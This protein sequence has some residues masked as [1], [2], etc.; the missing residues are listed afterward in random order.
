MVN[1]F[2]HNVYFHIRRHVN[3]WTNIDFGL[4]ICL[5]YDSTRAVPILSIKPYIK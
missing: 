2:P 1:C 3:L 4:F 5:V